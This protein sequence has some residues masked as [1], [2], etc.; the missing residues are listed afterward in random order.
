[1]FSFR[2]LLSD[3]APAAK[4][5]KHDG[6]PFGKQIVSQAL[7]PD[8]YYC[9]QLIAFLAF[10]CAFRLIF[11]LF[12]FLF[13]NCFQICNPYAMVNRTLTPD[14]YYLSLVSLV[15]LRMAAHAG[16][17]S[18]GPSNAELSLT[19]EIVSPTSADGST[20]KRLSM[21]RPHKFWGTSR[22]PRVPMR[23]TCTLL[24]YADD[25]GLFFTVDCQRKTAMDS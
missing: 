23:S 20:P 3:D 25:E 6:F 4:P 21:S 17:Q 19:T 9:L 2:L 15:C 7:K 8:S 24:S 11:R 18:A 5:P 10:I 12:F 14:P 22:C 1:M 13:L 16:G